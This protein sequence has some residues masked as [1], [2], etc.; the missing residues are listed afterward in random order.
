MILHVFK[1]WI[2]HNKKSRTT[3]NARHPS[4]TNYW[5]A[6]E[7][8]MPFNTIQVMKFIKWENN[9]LLL[10]KTSEFKLVSPDA[11]YFARNAF[12]VV[13]V[14]SGNTAVIASNSGVI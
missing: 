6:S 4:F 9:R 5:G 13:F 7:R 8:A 2:I 12:E 3:E 10:F 14:V 11:H 1:E